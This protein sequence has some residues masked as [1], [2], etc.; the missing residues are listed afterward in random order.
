MKL[1]SRYWLIPLIPLIQLLIASTLYICQGGFGGGHG[2]YDFPI[3]MFSV[4]GIYLI[5]WLPVNSWSMKSDFLL[6]LLPSAIIN[7]VLWSLFAIVIRAVA[8]RKQLFRH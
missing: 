5:G 3:Q 8:K 6:L 1:S 4:P 2:K 7:M